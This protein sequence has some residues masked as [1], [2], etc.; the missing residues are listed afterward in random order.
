MKR[1]LSVVII[2]GLLIATG[3]IGIAFHLTEIDPHQR[4]SQEQIWILLVRLTAI[5]AGVFMLRA[6]N[7]ARWLALA[8]IAFHVILSF[9]HSVQQV[10]VHA[11]LL[12]LFAWFLFRPEANAYFRRHKV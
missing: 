1:S 9:Y 5:I 10:V 7:W 11:V 4:I 8:W 2:A 12:A 6:A 3:A